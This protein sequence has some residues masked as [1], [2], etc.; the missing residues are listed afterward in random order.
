MSDNIV[1]QTSNTAPMV[2]HYNPSYDT[3]HIYE[4]L[5]DTGNDD[6]QEESNN[7]FIYEELPDTGNDDNQ[8][9]SNNTFIGTF[10]HFL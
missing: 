3:L 6:N 4:E 10:Y 9:E 8:E 2:S 5:P 7:S 1:Y